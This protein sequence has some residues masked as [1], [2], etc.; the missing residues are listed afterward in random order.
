MC[1]HVIIDHV[2]AHYLLAHRTVINVTAINVSTLQLF[3]FFI[4]NSHGLAYI[5]FLAILELSVEHIE[6]LGIK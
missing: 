6:L 2:F 1:E 4:L 3:V 5:A